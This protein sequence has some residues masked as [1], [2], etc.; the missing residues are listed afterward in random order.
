[1]KRFLL[2]FLALICFT[3]VAQ[4]GAVELTYEYS[5]VGLGEKRTVTLIASG[6]ESLSVLSAADTSEQSKEDFSLG[7]D[8][9]VGRQVYRNA[10][11]GELVFRDFVSR[12]G[13]FEA[14]LVRDPLKYSWTFTSETKTIGRYACRQAKTEFRGRRYQVWY[15]EEL[16]VAQGPWKFAGLP[17]AMVE[18]R[19]DD[20]VISF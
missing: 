10:A 9:A 14:C 15:C 3:A 1:M 17:G 19:S 6:R 13:K 5:N 11:T 20:E 8:D 2:P 12:N 16:A 7:G 4:R 18:I